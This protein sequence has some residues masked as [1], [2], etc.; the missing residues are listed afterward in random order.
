[1]NSHLKVVQ[2]LDSLTDAGGTAFMPVI[3]SLKPIVVGS[4]ISSHT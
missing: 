2:D 1:M 4:Q 3:N